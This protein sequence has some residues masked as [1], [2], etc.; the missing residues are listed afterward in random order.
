MTCPFKKPQTCF[1]CPF[2]DCITTG[3]IRRS[4][5]E[6]LYRLAGFDPGRR[7]E[8]RR[9]AEPEKRKLGKIIQVRV[10]LPRH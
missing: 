8:K 10:N 2:A 7:T 5:G 1:K 3:S 6:Y 9:F 4:R